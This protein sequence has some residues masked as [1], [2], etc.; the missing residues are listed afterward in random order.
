M[1]EREEIGAVVLGLPV[2]LSGE[3]G[4]KAAEV[5]RF[6]GWLTAATGLVPLLWD[7]RFTTVQ[8]ESFLNSAGLTNK[9]RK[10]RRDQ[11]AAQKLI[12]AY[13]DAGCPPEQVPGPLD[14]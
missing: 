6:A 12:Q 1:I 13:L 5:R 11:V 4:A 7:E 3:E 10:A 2:H 14:Q 8:A 9:K